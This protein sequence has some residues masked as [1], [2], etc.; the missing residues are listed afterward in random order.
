MVTGGEGSSR[1]KSVVLQTLLESCYKS[2]PLAT[3]FHHFITQSIA[4]IKYTLKFVGE[5]GFY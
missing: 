3:V 4:N 1:G 2:A 5:H